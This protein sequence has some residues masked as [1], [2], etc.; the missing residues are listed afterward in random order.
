MSMLMTFIHKHFKI[1]FKFYALYYFVILLLLCGPKAIEGGC[2][3]QESLACESIC[4][5]EGIC[6]IRVIVILPNTTDIEPS[7]PRVIIFFNKMDEHIINQ[8]IFLFTGAASIR[9]SQ[10]QNKRIW[11]TS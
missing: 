7:L 11:N 10:N 5:S 6:E 9:I 3:D 4:N 2:R 1:N 8:F